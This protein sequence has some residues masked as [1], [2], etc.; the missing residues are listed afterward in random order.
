MGK[1]LTAIQI[2]MAQ[3]WRSEGKGLTE[4]AELLDCSRETVRQ[5]TTPALLKK[6][7]GKHKGR[8]ALINEAK[9]QKIKACL[10]VLSCNSCVGND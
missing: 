7:A 9:F 5:H 2:R 8:P 4:C 3:R 1:H 10:P 6:K